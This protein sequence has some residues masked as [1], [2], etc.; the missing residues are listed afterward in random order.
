MP[1]RPARWR[2]LKPAARIASLAFW[3]DEFIGG[4]LHPHRAKHPESFER[5]FL[6]DFYRSS[7]DAHTQIMVSYPSDNPER[8]TGMA[9]W[10]RVGDGGKHMEA[11]Q[12]WLYWVMSR[13]I[14][15]IYIGVD[16]FIRRN[17][18]ADFAA[19]NDMKDSDLPMDERFENS[20]YN[21]TWDLELLFQAPQYQGRGFGKE[22]VSWGIARAREEGIRVSVG[23]APGK[24]GFYK[25]LG[26]DEVVEQTSHDGKKD[27]FPGTL[28]YSRRFDEEV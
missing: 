8:I 4:C 12:S 27:P 24:E 2:D 15:P 11:S 25:S 22:L 10:S 21:E 26:I 13:C 28:L 3:E 1:V 16:S 14:V 18:A 7:F 23:S 20:E 19:W 5:H 6:H 17:R 9:I